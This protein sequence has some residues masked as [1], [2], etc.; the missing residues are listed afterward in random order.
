[1]KES[2]FMS[3]LKQSKTKTPKL[4]TIPSPCKVR[5]R[6]PLTSA[7]HNSLSFVR[8]V[9]QPITKPLSSVGFNVCQDSGYISRM[10]TQVEN[11]ET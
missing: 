4:L 9:L 6:D 7:N 1:M 3:E 8:L 10:F 2:F 5:G 11:K